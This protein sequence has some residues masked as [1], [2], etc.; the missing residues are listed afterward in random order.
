MKSTCQLSLVSTASKR[1]G[2]YN[3]YVSGRVGVPQ[4]QLVSSALLFATMTTLLKQVCRLQQLISNFYINLSL[5]LSSIT[6]SL[7]LNHLCLFIKKYA[8]HIGPRALTLLI[9]TPFA[10]LCSLVS[11]FP[12]IIIV[13][14]RRWLAAFIL[15]IMIILK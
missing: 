15:S 9:Q 1:C 13:L 4:R 7:F 3:R 10:A 11:R 6:Y 5:Y 14:S 8:N 12:F 2:T